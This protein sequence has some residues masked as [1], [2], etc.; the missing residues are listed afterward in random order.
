MEALGVRA[1]LVLVGGE[2][3]PRLVVR[4]RSRPCIGGRCSLLGRTAYLVVTVPRWWPW[5]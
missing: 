3:R 5:S 4:A 1:H 2:R